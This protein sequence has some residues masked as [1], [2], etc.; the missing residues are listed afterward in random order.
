MYCT[1]VTLIKMMNKNIFD[2]C[3]FLMPQEDIKLSKHKIS[4][5]SNDKHCFQ[6]LHPLELEVINMTHS[7][8]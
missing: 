4:K 7:A 5:E 6:N 3:N 8:D 1:A 2:S